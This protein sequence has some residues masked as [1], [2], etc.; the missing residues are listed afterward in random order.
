MRSPAS[1]RISFSHCSQRK[2][3]SSPLSHP[4][5]PPRPFPKRR[6][7]RTLPLLLTTALTDHEIVWEKAIARIVFVLATVASGFPVLLFVMCL[8][9]VEVELIAAGYALATGT[10][11]LSGSIGICSACQLSDTRKA[12]IEA[13]V[14]SLCT[15]VPLLLAAIVNHVPNLQF[16]CGVACPAVQIGFACLLL[17]AGSR[18]LRKAGATAGPPPA[19]EFPEPPRGRSEPVGVEPPETVPTMLPLGKTDPVLWRERHAKARPVRGVSLLIAYGA[20][21]ALLLFLDGGWAI[22]KRAMKALDPDHAVQYLSGQVGQLDQGNVQLMVAGLIAS[23][24]YLLPLAVG[25]TGCIAGERLR[26]TLD[27]LLTTA[28]DRRRILAAKARVHAE[29]GLVFAGGAA[30]GLGA[31]FGAEGGVQLAI[32]AVAAFAGGTAFVV[33]V[34]AWLSVRCATPAVAFRLCVPAI[35]AVVGL[36]VL[37]WY[38]A[39]W[40]NVRPITELFVWSAGGF[41]LLGGVMWWRAGVNLERGDQ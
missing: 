30:T 4:G 7:G 38:F 9:G 37:A 40:E 28:L 22:V 16:I 32:A 3:C 33:G 14:L 39:N 25:V 31:G 19:S 11:V 15:Q 24:L 8:G 20:A 41:G 17:N 26:G 13:C 12:L 21:I 10:A 2:S 18:S 23:V 5:T 29:H 35:A 34:S 6:I 36:P 1:P 27:S